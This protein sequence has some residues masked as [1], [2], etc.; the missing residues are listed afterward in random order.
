MQSRQIQI[1]GLIGTMILILFIVIFLGKDFHQLYLNYTQNS[2]LPTLSDDQ[3]VMDAHAVRELE[4]KLN[5]ESEAVLA[6]YSLQ[7]SESTAMTEEKGRDFA[8]SV[9]EEVHTEATVS[10]ALVQSDEN[11]PDKLSKEAGETEYSADD[12]SKPAAEEEKVEKAVVS[13]PVSASVSVTQTEAEKKEPGILPVETA[14]INKTIHQILEKG[15]FFHHGLVLSGENRALLDQVAKKVKALGSG[16]VLEVE[17]H[18]K[19]GVAK[20]VSGKMAIKAAAYLRKKLPGVTVTTVGYGN[21]YPVSDDLKD[22]SNTRIEVIVR[23]SVR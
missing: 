20:A 16:Y 13:K 9:K 21:E 3:I 4:E 10:A 17:G 5:E 12:I 18:T 11:V 2:T 15:T 8:P 19:Q 7:S 23:R 1:F 22:D 14:K 6:G